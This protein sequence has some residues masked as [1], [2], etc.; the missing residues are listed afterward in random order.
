MLHMRAVRRRKKRSRQLA[1]RDH[2]QDVEGSPLLVFCKN[3]PWVKACLVPSK[4]SNKKYSK[5]SHGVGFWTR[6]AWLLVGAKT[7]WEF[8]W[9]SVVE[10]D[11]DVI[12]ELPGI[13]Q[14]FWNHW[15]WFRNHR[16]QGWGSVCWGGFQHID[17][18]RCTTIFQDPKDSGLLIFRDAL[19]FKKWSSELS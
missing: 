5:L 19:R 9:A 6:C 16:V 17:F 10:I 3:L 18:P 11:I 14:T 15:E 8:E 7:C 13:T 2:I 4:Q 12:A 1:I